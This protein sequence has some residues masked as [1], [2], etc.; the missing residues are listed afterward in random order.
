[1]YSNHRPTPLER[2]LKVPEFFIQILRP[3][4]NKDN[5]RFTAVIQI[6]PLLI[7]IEYSIG[8]KF[9]CLQAVCAVNLN[10]WIL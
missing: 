9:Y 6:K 10:I 1:M 7:S 2:Y 5:N 3:C 4:T 8:A